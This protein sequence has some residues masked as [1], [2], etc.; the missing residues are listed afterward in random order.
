MS[1]KC[2]DVFDT[3]LRWWVGASEENCEDF[4]GKIAEHYPDIEFVLVYTSEDGLCWNE[5][6][7]NGKQWHETGWYSE[8]P[9]VP[10][11]NEKSFICSLQEA[12]TLSIPDLEAIQ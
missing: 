6:E 12:V 2:L 8:H 5:Y 4:F 3:R 9:D 1:D 11:D 7:W 10:T